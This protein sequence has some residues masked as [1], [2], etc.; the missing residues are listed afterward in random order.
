[1]NTLTA[2][3]A[4]NTME[5]KDVNTCLSFISTIW[6][7]KPLVLVYDN[8]NKHIISSWFDPEYQ[9]GDLTLLEDLIEDFLQ[10]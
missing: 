4:K 5:L 3:I 8:L 6:R 1:M 7:D 10:Q 2:Y 9:V